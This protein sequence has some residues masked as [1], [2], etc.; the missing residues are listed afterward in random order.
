MLMFSGPCS[1]KVHKN[2]NMA[3]RGELSVEERNTVT[4]G[5]GKIL[6]IGRRC[7]KELGWH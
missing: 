6:Y 4:S 7:S 2:K 5:T 3:C 1:E